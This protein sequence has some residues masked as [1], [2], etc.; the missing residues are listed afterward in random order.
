MHESN[1][2]IIRTIELT[3]QLIACADIGDLDREDDTC[4]VF[5]GIVRD[6]AYK[7]LHEAEK[8]R[9]RHIDRG[10]WKVAP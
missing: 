10:W 4:G 1:E 2:N 9:L 3:R 5:Y 7:I 8:E 6:N